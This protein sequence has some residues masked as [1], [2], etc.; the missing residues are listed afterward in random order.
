LRF[1]GLRIADCGAGDGSVAGVCGGALPVCGSAFLVV[2]LAVGYVVGL[3][4]V[5]VAGFRE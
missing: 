1:E 3:G 2:V 4:S 5:A